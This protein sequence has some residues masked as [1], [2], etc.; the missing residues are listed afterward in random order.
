M[1]EHLPP[2]LHFQS[3]CGCAVFLAFGF[4]WLFAFTFWNRLTFWKERE[5]YKQEIFVVTGARY[6]PST[7]EGASVDSYWLEGTVGGVRERL[8]PDR[9][10]APPPRSAD[11]LASRYPKGTKINVLYNPDVTIWAVQD[12]SLRVT[13]ARPDFWEREASRRLV[14]GVLTLCPV[15]LTLIVYFVVRFVNHRRLAK[16]AVD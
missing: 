8:I 7:G 12:E 1:A 16:Q 14:F 4:S 13:E 3:C 5:H 10:G 9:H 6:V 11:E 2:R 15:P